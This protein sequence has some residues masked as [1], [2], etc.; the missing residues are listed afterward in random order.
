MVAYVQGL[1]VPEHVEQVRYSLR[2]PGPVAAELLAMT[3]YWHKASAAQR[4]GIRDRE[5]MDVMVDIR[6]ARYR[7]H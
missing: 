1:P 2:L 5:E 6:V 3:P 4:R 7:L